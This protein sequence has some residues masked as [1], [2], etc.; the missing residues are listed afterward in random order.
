MWCASCPTAMSTHRQAHPA[1]L[2]CKAKQ[3]KA[4]QSKAKQSKANNKTNA[5]NAVPNRTYRREQRHRNGT[6]L[7]RAVLGKNGSTLEPVALL[8]HVEGKDAR[9]LLLPH[10]QTVAVL[11]TSRRHAKGRKKEGG[12]QQDMQHAT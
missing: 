7:V 1:H 4:K 12:K 3:S 11:P 9:E 2:F 8:L 5:S 6:R 10:L